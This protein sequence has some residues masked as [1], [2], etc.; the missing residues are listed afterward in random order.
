M[1]SA[2]IFAVPALIFASACERNGQTKSGVVPVAPAKLNLL[3]ERK[4]PADPLERARRAIDELRTTVS[5]LPRSVR[6]RFEPKVADIE[7]DAGLI[8]ATLEEGRPTDAREARRLLLQLRGVPLSLSLLM[9]D[10]VFDLHR[11]Q[12]PE[13]TGHD[14]S[15]A[16][17][18]ARKAWID[19]ALQLESNE[20]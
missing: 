7:T 18:E 9:T 14:L 6:D 10:V 15:H 17:E 4:Q 20:A 19:L 5:G 13:E 8:F 3:I 12:L 16:T 11:A 2:L 1:K